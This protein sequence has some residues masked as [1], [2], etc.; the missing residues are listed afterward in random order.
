M[1]II[2]KSV[3]V[4]MT[5]VIIITSCISLGYASQP[6]NDE[7]DALFSLSD[8]KQK[9]WDE[10]YPVFTTE[11]FLSIAKVFKLFFRIISGRIFYAEEYTTVEVDEFVTAACDYVY[12]NSGL[13]IVSILT[14]V[15]DI[16][17]LPEFTTKVFNIDPV[18]F[19]RQMYEKR[20]QYDDEGNDVMS[21][22]CNFL[23]AYMSIIDK[24]E[25]FSDVTGSDP[26]VHEVMLKFVYRDGG[27]NI[28]HTGIYI[29]VA[30]GECTNYNDSGLCGTG[31]NFSLSEML[32]YA[33]ISAWMRDFG[34][35]LFYDLAAGSMPLLWN[36]RTRRFTFDYD[37]LEWMI[38]IW[39]GNYL[40]TNGGE[41][42]VYNRTPDKF[43]TFYSCATD[44]QL[45]EMTLQ[46]Y[47]GEDLLVNQEPQMHWWINGFQMSDKMYIP[48]SLTM[49]AS[50]VMPNEEMLNAF[51]ESIDNHYRKDV[52]YTVD[53]LKISLAW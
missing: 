35:C 42:G 44:D 27:Y 51:C 15:P 13:D 48:E 1:N 53:G 5:I 21:G 16:S 23:G 36:Y 10:G 31:F 43:G 17:N 22:I 45:M 47:H 28:S 52:T 20:D 29:N 9:L 38:Q 37:G 19:R 34:F 49:N 32:V 30:T 33:T 11:Q 25:V 46:I 18:E 39:K 14:S 26:N 4:L 7:S 12:L 40:I 50:I 24:I 3:S 2:K 41:L 8:Y 6:N